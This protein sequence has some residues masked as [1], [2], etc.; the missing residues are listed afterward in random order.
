MPE[1]GKPADTFNAKIWGFFG[2]TKTPAP[3]EGE[4][5]ESAEHRFVLFALG[6]PRPF[7][8]QALAAV[9]VPESLFKNDEQAQEWIAKTKNLFRTHAQ[10]A[11]FNAL[12]ILLFD[13]GN[14]A[15]IEMNIAS[16]DKRGMLHGH[17]ALSEKFARELLKPEAGRPAQWTDIELSEAIS[18]A[19]NALLSRQ[20]NYDE[21][22]DKLREVYG[23]RAPASGG[24]LRQQVIRLGLNWKELKSEAAKRRKPARVSYVS[25]IE[26]VGNRDTFPTDRN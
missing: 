24:A 1:N 23:E 3:V 13:A 5:Q 6:D 10:D 15:L 16:T 12:R 18:E 20:R 11:I 19:M 14:L 8:Y 7:P 4:A 25:H 22:A 21:V 26:N 17:L 9:S 2:E